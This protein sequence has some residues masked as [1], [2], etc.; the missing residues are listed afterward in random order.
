[1]SFTVSHRPATHGSTPQKGL[2]DFRCFYDG[3]PLVFMVVKDGKLQSKTLNYDHDCTTEMFSLEYDQKN[4]I[5]IEYED[6]IV[7]VCIAEMKKLGVVI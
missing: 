3:S 1:M 7:E 2:Y 4:D 5:I 6:H